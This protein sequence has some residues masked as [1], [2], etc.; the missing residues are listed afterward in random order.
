[1]E[2]DDYYYGPESYDIYEDKKLEEEW[3]K[4]ND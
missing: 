3:R 1:M 4:D 2:M